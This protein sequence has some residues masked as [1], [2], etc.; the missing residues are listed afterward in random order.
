[1][2]ARHRL[3]G[4]AHPDPGKWVWLVLGR[5]GRRGPVG[6]GFERVGLR[7]KTSWGFLDGWLSKLWSLFGVPVKIRHL[8]FGVPKKGP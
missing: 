1:M 5:T 3:S 7:L 6:V 2:E 4:E 8:L